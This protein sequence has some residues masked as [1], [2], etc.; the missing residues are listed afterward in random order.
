MAWLVLVLIAQ[1]V[2]IGTAAV[3]ELSGLVTSAKRPG[4]FWAHG[5]S[6]TTPFLY[7]ITAEGRSAGDAVRVTGARGVDWE[8]VARGPDGTLYVGDVGNNRTDRR[9]LQILAVPEP[10]EGVT[11]AAVTRVL[12][13]SYPDQKTFP[14]P[15]FDAEALAFAGGRLLLFTKRIDDRAVCYALKPDV[16]VPQVAERVVE[17]PGTGMV[18]GAAVSPSGRQ[19]ALLAYGRV[20]ILDVADG[21]PAGRLAKTVKLD[22][23]REH[24]QLEAIAWDAHGLL[25]GSEKGGLFRITP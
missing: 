16:D 14:Q 22:I 5:D 20:S 13:F 2:P 7:P 12:R 11:E 10:R 23:P 9:D 24:A 4:V 15:G 8:D 19:I 18:T 6:G 1:D 25:L 17:I 3:P 21:R